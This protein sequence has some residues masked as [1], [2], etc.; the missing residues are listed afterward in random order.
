MD[1]ETI[2]IEEVLEAFLAEAPAPN[3]ATVQEWVSR[4]PQF[5]RE[6]VEAAASW[7]VSEALSDDFDPARDAEEDD[8]L[9]LRGMSLVQDRLYAQ[10]SEQ[11]GPSFQ[12]LLMEA[13]RVNLAPADVADRLEVGPVTLKKL[14]R[15]MIRP[16]SI[17]RIVLHRLADA[18]QTSAASIATYL[19]Q[20][21]SLP[22]GARYRA[23]SAPSLP[24]EQE[25]F[26]EAIRQ[27]RSISEETRNRWLDLLSE[28]DDP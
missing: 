15:R 12:S 7:A 25:D 2:A 16:G 21:M 14:D 17:P 20:P 22:S 8:T 5:R 18:L 19:G 23:A 10:K 26:H 11:P 9:V 4:Y 27:D 28:R 1:R 24:P 13:K 6:I 3:H